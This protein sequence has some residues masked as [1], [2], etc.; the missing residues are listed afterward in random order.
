MAK[1]IFLSDIDL[2]LNQLLQARLE[3]LGSDPEGIAGR[4]YYNTTGSGSVRY[5]DTVWRTI[6]HGADSRL[7]DART[8]TSH[9]IATNL[10]LGAQHTISGA[11][12]GSVLRASSATAANF[13]LL[14]HAD[15]LPASTGT[16]THAQI[17]SH[18]ADD[19]KHRLIDDGAI[20]TTNLYSASKI[21]SLI[22]AI[23]TT[24]SGSLVYKGGYDA[25][26]ND[27]KLDAAPFLTGVKQGWTYVVTVG[28]VFFTEALQVGDMVIA[29]KD[30]PTTLADWTTVNK[31]IPDIV[32]ATTT[33]EGITFL[34]TNAEAS[35]GTLTTKAI[36]PASLKYTLDNRPATLTGTGLIEL[37]TDTEASVGAD[38]VRAVV[39]SALKYT[40]D[41]RNASETGTGLIELATQAEASLGTDTTRAITPATL[42][43][44]LGI[45]T[46]LSNVRKF[47]AQVGNNSATEYVVVHGLG[48]IP[49]TVT[50]YNTTLFNVVDTQVVLTSANS[51]TVSFNKAPATNEYTVVVMG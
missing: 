1:K 41:N 33:T 32:S 8:P 50:I 7:S 11:P 39:P 21:N 45:T 13:Q 6:V 48:V 26:T 49:V 3:N 31:N 27:P 9:V 37:A 14:S 20:T 28:G 29:K 2:A 18:L 10:A 25:A 47:T 23:N 44:V 12:V 35:T 46:T 19:T 4:I 5:F 15:L 34:A 36:V 30:S 42:K 51:I 24:I 17:D 38:T 43:G 40:L 22:E 16:N